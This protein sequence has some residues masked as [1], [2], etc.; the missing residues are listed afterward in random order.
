MRKSKL[1]YSTN[2]ISQAKTESDII[3]SSF[4]TCMKIIRK[5]KHDEC[6]QNNSMK[7]F[8]LFNGMCQCNLDAFN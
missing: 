3:S 4:N 7:V 6:F 1:F 5:T 2:T 8:V